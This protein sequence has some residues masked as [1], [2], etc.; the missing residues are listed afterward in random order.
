MYSKV[1]TELVMRCFNV[2][3]IVWQKVA[4]GTWGEDTVNQL[5]AYIQESN[6]V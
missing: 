6:P 3:K 2:G 4:V 5:V 1:N